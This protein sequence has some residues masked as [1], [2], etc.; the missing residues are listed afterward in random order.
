MQATPAT[1]KNVL[2][3]NITALNKL[4]NMLIFVKVKNSTQYPDP[5][6]N[7]K[8]FGFNCCILHHADWKNEHSIE[9][10]VTHPVNSE[11]QM[12]LRKCKKNIKE[13][14][15]AKKTNASLHQAYFVMDK[16]GE[17]K[18]LP[19]KHAT[20]GKHSIA[21][22][23]NE[24]YIVDPNAASKPETKQPDEEAGGDEEADAIENETR[25]EDNDD[26]K[27]G[28]TD[29]IIKRP[30]RSKRIRP[31][32][33]LSTS[34]EPEPPFKKPR[35]E[36]SATKTP[37]TQPKIIETPKIPSTSAAPIDLTPAY[38][39]YSLVF[40]RGVQIPATRQDMCMQLF[41]KL[42]EL[43]KE[44]EKQLK[45]SFVFLNNFLQSDISYKQLHDHLAK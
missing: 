18:E 26:S 30:K 37:E 27:E 40:G 31:N 9:I 23:A 44:D 15:A 19:F 2:Q 14:L 7:Q 32:D 38:A 39:H 41:P 28:S 3:H 12:T 6:V 22:D 20:Q 21:M 13:Y 35:T 11:T 43:P 45:P 16:N 33:E 36:E 34:D 29:E 24:M 17:L 5:V 42:L 10:Y 8:T 4:K 25:E 1:K